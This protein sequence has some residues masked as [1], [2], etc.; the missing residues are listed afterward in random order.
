MV[1]L[2]LIMGLILFPNIAEFMFLK[3]CN[4]GGSCVNEKWRNGTHWNVNCMEWMELKEDEV[5]KC[6]KPWKCCHTAEYEKR[7]KYSEG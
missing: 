3:V 4:N 2:W 6:R 1:L 7:I 5:D